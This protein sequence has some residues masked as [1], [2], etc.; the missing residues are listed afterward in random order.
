MISQL[1]EGVILR[2]K[3]RVKVKFRE[4]STRSDM[5]FTHRLVR[6]TGKVDA[7]NKGNFEIFQ[8][9]SYILTNMK[10]QINNEEEGKTKRHEIEITYGTETDEENL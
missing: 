10:D 3:K 6:S 2:I 5:N 7:K 9:S 1:S 4:K 8:Q